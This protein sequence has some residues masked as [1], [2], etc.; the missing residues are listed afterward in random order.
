MI[1]TYLPLNS[2]HLPNEQYSNPLSQATPPVPAHYWQPK[3]VWL[4]TTS[5][6]RPAAAAT[7]TPSLLNSSQDLPLILHTFRHL[8]TIP[9]CLT[10]TPLYYQVETPPILQTAPTNSVWRVPSYPS[11]A[12][13]VWPHP[14]HHSSY[15]WTNRILTVHWIIRWLLYLNWPH[16]LVN[17]LLWAQ[18]LINWY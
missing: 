11:R 15:N 6:N 10:T 18:D 1:W 14:P 7:P 8:I 2:T 9:I 16:P 13:T 4:T 3:G 5:L 12:V 17:F